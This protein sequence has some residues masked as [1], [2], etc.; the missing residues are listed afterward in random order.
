MIGYTDA[1]FISPKGEIINTPVKHIKSVLDNPEKF[2]LNREVIE[3]IYD[4]YGEKYGQ[5]GKAR[6]QILISLINQGWIRIR[7][8]GDKFWTVNVHKITPKIKGYLN[9]WANAVLKGKYG[10]KERDKEI[11]VKIDQKDKKVTSSNISDIANS[12][13]FVLEG[14]ETELLFKDIKDLED[15]P[16][17]PEA[18][19][20]MKMIK[21]L[22]K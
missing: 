4:T 13:G 21:Y 8:Y 12:S 20:I 5:E 15:R 18:Q 9:K 19:R 17:I 10:F 1:Y 2:G 14:K 7:K 3:Y 11:P 16:L 6:E 22:E